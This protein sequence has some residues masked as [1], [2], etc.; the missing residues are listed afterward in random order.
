M[1]SSSMSSNR[2]PRGPFTPQVDKDT[3]VSLVP[4]KGSKLDAIPP[5]S[6]V[7]GK[8]SADRMSLL[9][10]FN[11]AHFSCLNR[12][13]RSESQQ[14]ASGSLTMVPSHALDSDTTTDRA[15]QRYW[16]VGVLIL[17][18]QAAL[19]RQNSRAS[20]LLRGPS[21]PGC[22]CARSTA[23]AASWMQGMGASSKQSPPRRCGRRMLAR[24]LVCA[25]DPHGVEASKALGLS[26]TI[27]SP[28]RPLNGGKASGTAP[29]C[30]V[31]LVYARQSL[32]ILRVH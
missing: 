5:R 12:A 3:T 19:V 15:W 31:S 30:S 32:I 1:A 13:A 8:P 24:S 25:N 2:A 4:S 28:R 11:S 21:N 6:R 20:K 22:C 16:S 14:S 27:G 7:G 23:A 26:C 10:K 9:S 18:R 17:Q 29:S